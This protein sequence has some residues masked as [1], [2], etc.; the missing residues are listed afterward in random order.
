MKC[1][2]MNNIKKLIILLIISL[3][4]NVV[5]FVFILTHRGG[6]L[7]TPCGQEINHSVKKCYIE[8]D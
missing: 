6:L 8:E 3:I 4:L 7:I 2:L 5:M 1:K